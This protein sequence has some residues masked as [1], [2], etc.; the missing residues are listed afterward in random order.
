MDNLNSFTS[1][2][3][4][5]YRGGGESQTRYRFRVPPAHVVEHGVHSLHWPQPPRSESVFIYEKKKS[6]YNHSM[7]EFIIHP[8]KYM[9]FTGIGTQTI[10][11][12]IL[13]D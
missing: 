4:A 5:P 1:Q 8:L 6:Y 10:S 9:H 13:A 2:N 11:T 3:M 7:V 12:R